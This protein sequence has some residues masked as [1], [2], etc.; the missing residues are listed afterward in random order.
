M[1]TKEELQIENDNLQKRNTTL[2]NSVKK[3][4]ENLTARD[5]TI[6]ELLNIVEYLNHR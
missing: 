5:K 6:S 2:N 4:K 1:T 3:L